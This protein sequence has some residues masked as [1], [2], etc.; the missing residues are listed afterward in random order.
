MSHILNLQISSA[1][2]VQYD[3]FRACAGKAISVKISPVSPW[4]MCLT[5]L[6]GIYMRPLFLTNHFPSNLKTFDFTPLGS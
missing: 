6:G 5:P 2:C 1:G 3:D 4:Y